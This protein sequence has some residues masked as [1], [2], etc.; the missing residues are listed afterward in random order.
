[1]GWRFQK[2]IK[3]MPGV[4]VNL[5]RSGVSASAGVPGASVNAGKDG[6][7]ANAGLPGTGLSSRSK[8]GGKTGPRA[9]LEDQ[10]ASPSAFRT[11]LQG[12]LALAVIAGIIWAI[13]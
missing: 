3:I 9:G 2:R 8:L 11:L 13:L 12:V 7:F 10:T 6:A 5:S 4:R 1:M